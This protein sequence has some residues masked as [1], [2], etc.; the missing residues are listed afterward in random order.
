M[1]ADEKR[2]FTLKMTVGIITA[3]IGFCMYSHSKIRKP[4]AGLLKGSADITHNL[5][6]ESLLQEQHKG[7]HE[8]DVPQVQRQT[9]V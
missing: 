6:T 3:L 9:K 5:Q 2:T 8:K 4:S 7:A 1:C